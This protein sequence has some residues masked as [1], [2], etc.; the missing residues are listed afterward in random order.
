[1]QITSISYLLFAAAVLLGYFLLPKKVRWMYLLASSLFFYLMAGVEYLGFL[2]LT[3]LSTYVGG[4]LMERN[5]SK[6]ERYLA[7]NK[8]SLSR[9]EKK[10]CKN[11][12]KI[13]NRLILAA[14]LVLNF[15]IL[16]ACKLGNDY[17]LWMLGLPFGISFYM[18][19]SMG[20][21][22]DI[23]RGT[24][25]AERNFFKLALFASYFPQLIQGPISKHSVL[26]PQLTAG[27]GFDGKAFSF[28]IQRMLWGF[29]KK[30]V[31]A[32]RIAAA[33]V[34]LR[35]PEYTGVGFFLLT[36]FYAV[37]IYADF[38]GGIDMVIGLSQALGITLPENFVRPYF[39]KNIAEYWRRWH[40][41][42]GEW[43]KSYIF[44]PISVS[45]P[46]LKL[47]KAARTK[48]GNFG[49]RL[50]V[51]AAS[52]ATW[53][54]TGIWHGLTPNFL[55]WGM[56]N[57]F[58][59]V[60]SEELNPLY[61]KFHNRLGFK[62]KKWYGGFEILRM[63]LL[64]NLIR[65]VDWFPDVGQYFS[66][67][68][69]LF[70]TFNFHVLWDGTLM[71]LGLTAL[72]YGILAF[73]IATMF[74]VSLFEETKGSIRERLYTRPVLRYALFVAL[75]LIVLL[76]GSYGIGYDAGNFIYNRF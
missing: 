75:L 22:V 53:A 42:L 29:F 32:D 62:E 34:I 15:G 76:M 33:V 35:G 63:F 67:M 19:Q 59:I 1:M 55:L 14:I 56:M 30:L 58:V 20:Y 25:K 52:V 17:S 64:M 16:G 5:L 18:F 44:Y 2:V 21:L 31:I 61:E 74:S 38:T 70:T 46:M 4:R 39:S 45:S 50:P 13:K 66:R 3:V 6:Q 54:V 11:R 26:A 60:V 24:D 49:K 73:G 57:C 8:D 41:S 7:E 65:V 72:D 12:I 10:A 37:Q 68:G 48:L 23:Y 27:K 28:G 47:S 51:Y 43:M 40:I 9:E 36:L 71:K 69:S